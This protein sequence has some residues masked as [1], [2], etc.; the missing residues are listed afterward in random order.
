MMTPKVPI[1]AVLPMTTLVLL[2]AIGG[3]C[4][5]SCPL[6]VPESLLQRQGLQNRR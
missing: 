3:P 1:A 6:V 4:P 5:R 2:S